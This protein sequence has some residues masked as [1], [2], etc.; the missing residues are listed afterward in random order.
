MASLN[1]EENVNFTR[2][3]RLLVDK[4][5]EAL[6]NTL[7]SIHP[8]ANLPTVLNAYKTTLLKLKFRI[9]N[10]SQWDL[11]FPPSGNPPDSKTFDVTLLAVLVRNICGLPAPATGWNTLP[12]DVDRSLAA[13]VTR[14]KLFRNQIFA[15]VSSTLVDNTTFENLWQKVSKALVDLK[16][17]Q[18]EINDLK[19]CPLGP[20]EEVYVQ[21]LKD[22][23]LKDE[24][25]EK[26]LSE[27]WAEVKLIRQQLEQSDLKRQNDMQQLSS[28]VIEEVRHGI[29]QFS[30][31]SSKQRK[32]E[33]SGVGR[34]QSSSVDSH[35]LLGLAKHNF[36]SKIRSKV[37]MFHHG[38]RKWLL[39]QLDDWFSEE[40][41]S[42]LL[43]IT[44]GP[45]FGKSVFSAKVCELFREKGKLAASHFCDFSDSNLND[46]MM[47]LQSLASQMCENIAG[48]KEELLDQLKRPHKVASLKDAFQIYLQNPLDELEA[49]PSLIVID[50]LDESATNDKSNILKLM[51]DHF[52]DLP[53]CVKVMVTSRPELS[54]QMLDHIKTIEVEA[55]DIN[56][57]TDLL[58]YLEDCFESAALH[59][60]LVQEIPRLVLEKWEGSFLYAFHFQH[61]LRK[62]SDLWT[63]EDIKDFL[64]KG[65]G[66]VYESYFRRLE[67]ELEIAISR[68]PE[69]F[70]ILELFVAADKPLPLTFFAR[71]LDLDPGCREMRRIIDKVNEALSCLLY[72]SN[73]SVTVFHKSVYDWLLGNGYPDHE[74]SVEISDGTKRLW[75]M[76]KQIFEELKKT[77]IS[78]ND[79][80][81]TIEV[82]H[83]LEYGHK[84]LL[85]CNIRDDFHWLVDMT[86]VHVFTTVLPKHARILKF[87][88]R[89]VLKSDEGLSFPLRKRISWH[90]VEFSVE[91]M[92]VEKQSCSYLKSVLNHSPQ[93]CF[94]ADEKRTAEVIVTRFPQCVNHE[95]EKKSFKPVLAKCFSPSITAVGVSSRKKLAAVALENGTICVL[96]LPEMVELFQYPTGLT[97]IP[98]C[99]FSPDDSVVLYGKLEKVLSI[100]KEKE[101]S[102]FNRERIAF[103][104]CSFSPNGKRLVTNNGSE[105]LMLWDVS[106]KILLSFFVGALPLTCCFFS[107]NGLFIIGNQDY[108]YEDSYCVWSAITF[109]RVDLR[110]HS[111]KRMEGKHQLLR[112]ERCERCCRQ[113]R[114]DLIP[115]KEVQYV[116]EEINSTGIYN[117]FECIFHLDGQ[118]LHVV[119]SIHL[120]TLAIWGITI[121]HLKCCMSHVAIAAIEDNFWLYSDE[122]Q[123]VVYLPPKENQSYL[124]CPTRVLWCCFSP[125]G[126][127]LASVTS[128]GFIRLWHVDTSEV[129]QRFRSNIRSMSAAC[130][131]SGEYLL[132]C[133]FKDRIPI[134]MKY[135]VDK[136]M[137]IMSTEMLPKSLLPIMN[138][139]SSVSKIL[140]F[141]EGYISFEC[142]ET[143]PVKVIDVSET[144]SPKIVVLPEIEPM[145]KIAVSEGGS[146]ILG[147]DCSILVWKRNEADPAA[148]DILTRY[149]YESPLYS[150]G[151]CCFSGD[152][153]FVVCFLPHENK[154]GFLDVDADVCVT[155]VITDSDGTDMSEAEV[156]GYNIFPR[157][158][159]GPA[160][161][162][163]SNS[164]L[165]LVT[166]KLIKIFG[167]NSRRSLRSSFHWHLNDFS[168]IHSKLSPKGTVL[169]VPRLTGVVDFF[170]I[171]HPE[172][173]Q[174]Y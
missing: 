146:L 156:T 121:T 150:V 107:K 18:K 109:Q 95:N 48:F 130:C 63:V 50:G 97:R 173:S 65:M 158:S 120:R 46:P 127:R 90:F 54:V 13:N 114:K 76:C 108:R 155:K 61:E 57:E 37:N 66:S 126:S 166:S 161:V 31:F 59:G 24:G 62:R 112:S 164:V 26:I 94:T 99:T 129:Y 165:I 15:H 27:V 88:W 160:E 21:T 138:W 116:T 154:M 91:K 53:N 139:F 51:T 39:K 172:H 32:A 144:E 3:S 89:D 60:R 162:F 19:A 86:I 64:P 167:R 40:D 85:S 14:I 125:D 58:K 12:P 106:R 69:L 170:Q 77:V 47:M 30:H 118:F 23:V 11:L 92:E 169:A 134:L 73:D 153:K 74:Y 141:S 42:R 105:K 1:L 35:L 137:T 168:S 36:K 10:D 145:M 171:C 75:Q 93:G 70:K 55:D 22:W 131:W 81:P 4:G 140:D 147:T 123:L 67:V 151:S 119:E 111:N 159:R 38:T 34:K 56:N 100:E 28:S 33:E 84:Y 80:K 135:P 143:T 16:I 9:I 25:C 163:C 110:S 132:V 122:Y 115:Q 157:F 124:L 41:E 87:R 101:T 71:T 20:N 102:Y 117:N 2:L 82:M 83:V 79:V 174:G 136:N 133:Y 113:A 72:V 148:Y 128:D 5:T 98:C 104:S 17:P 8:A 44:A 6:R 7:E 29:Q 52:P 152:S 78:G 149:G 45:G 49:E 43:L 103:K 68:K 142:G 96:S